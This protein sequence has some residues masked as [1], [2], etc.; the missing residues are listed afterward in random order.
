ME[1]EG[2]SK[3]RKK[4]TRG[5]WENKV[6]TEK[7]EAVKEG[8]MGDEAEAEEHGS[9]DNNRLEGGSQVV[10]KPQTKL[11]IRRQLLRHFTSHRPVFIIEEKKKKKRKQIGSSLSSYLAKPGDCVM[12]SKVLPKADNLWVCKSY[13]YSRLLV[14]LRYITAVR[15]ASTEAPRWWMMQM[16]WSFLVENVRLIMP[17]RVLN[18]LYSVIAV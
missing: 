13:M 8:E 10:G 17:S 5:R 16:C 14:W 9:N 15:V 2:R 7:N 3:T 18:S 1:Y 11:V 4:G 12:I 6:G